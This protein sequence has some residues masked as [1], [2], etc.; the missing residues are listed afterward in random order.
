MALA[1]AMAHVFPESDTDRYQTWLTYAFIYVLRVFVWVL[2]I[3]LF[4]KQIELLKSKLWS[5]AAIGAVWSGILEQ[6]WGL[7]LQSMGSASVPHS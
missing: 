4:T 6:C 5:Y 3:S 2:V 7:H 1:Y